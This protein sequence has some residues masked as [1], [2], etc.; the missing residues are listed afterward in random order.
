[1]N[2]DF[3]LIL[4][5]EHAKGKVSSCRQRDEAC[6]QHHAPA[7]LPLGNTR[8]PLYRRL[9]EHWGRS[10]RHGKYRPQQG[11]D[12]QTVQNAA[13]RQPTEL[14]RPCTWKQVNV[15]RVATNCR[16]IPTHSSSSFNTTSSLTSLYR[17]PA[18]N[19]QVV[20]MF[21]RACSHGVTSSHNGQRFVKCTIRGNA[22]LWKLSVPTVRNIDMSPLQE[23][24]SDMRTVT[25]AF[26]TD[27]VRYLR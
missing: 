18:G 6:G 7:A 12:P 23:W 20:S 9:G 13:S 24:S 15:K 1:V 26:F 27:F 2:S 16:C 21:S 19:E 8:Y 25:L 4:Y 5:K 3:L 10:E 11:F 17:R 14:S 22:A